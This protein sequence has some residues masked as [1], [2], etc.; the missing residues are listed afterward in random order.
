M[1]VKQSLS[2]MLK[3]S[4]ENRIKIGTQERDREREIRDR[5]KDFILHLKVRLLVK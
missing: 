3:M 5:V 1:V 2:V 4:A